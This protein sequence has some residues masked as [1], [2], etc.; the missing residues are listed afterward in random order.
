LIYFLL[1]DTQ[2]SDS[3]FAAVNEGRP[4]TADFG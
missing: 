4:C 1:V 2:S 3:F